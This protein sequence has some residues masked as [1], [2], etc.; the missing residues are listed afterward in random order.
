MLYSE[1]KFADLRR[2]NPKSGEI[3]CGGKAD[4]FSSCFALFKSQK[5]WFSF[6]KSESSFTSDVIRQVK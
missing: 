6:K 3:V 1:N 2:T 4:Q 5:S